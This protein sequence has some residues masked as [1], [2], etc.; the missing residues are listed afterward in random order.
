MKFLARIFSAAVIAAACGPLLAQ[1][2]NLRFS[3][4]SPPTNIKVQAY[5]KWADLT[6]QKSN[7]RINIR[8]FPSAQLYNDVN[9]IPAVSAGTV[10]LAAP[11]SSLLTSVVPASA[12]FELPSLWGISYD[13]YRKLL[14]G[15]FGT[16][17]AKDYE[18]KLGVK[19]IGHYNIGHWVWGTSAKSRLITKPADFQNQKIRVVGNPVV[20][21]TL[22]GFGANPTQL[23]WPEVPTALLQGVIDGLETTL[24]GLDSV[25]G[26]EL[27]KNVTFSNHKYLPFVV[28]MNKRAWDRVPADMQKVMLDA[29]DESRK[30][31]DSEVEKMNAAA[32][33]RFKS[34]GA[35]VHL[36]SA[37]ELKAFSDA[38]QPAEKAFLDSS[39]LA[40]AAA[41]ARKSAGR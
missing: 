23:A 26:W 9:A 13:Q 4:D 15:E 20:E 7:G 27:T 41:S 1:E 31:H 8:I 16:Q 11:P 40:A 28:I 22:K 39:G 25:K 19:V 5:Q 2:I 34:N 14:E 33:D 38:A 36:L 21:R 10:D 3:A 18:A 29:M 35:T 17:L 37:A 32:I 12:V 6:K 30:W 24:S